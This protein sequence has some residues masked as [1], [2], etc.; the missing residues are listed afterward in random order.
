MAST[1]ENDV[2]QI[3]L[4]ISQLPGTIDDLNNDTTLPELGYTGNMCNQ[5]AQRLD[6]YVKSKKTATG[7][8]NAEIA[9]D[10]TVQ[11]IIDLITK[12]LS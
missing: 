10:E 4:V 5:L 12:K 9:C 6:H 8:S 1:I 2:K 11:D 7:V 3:I